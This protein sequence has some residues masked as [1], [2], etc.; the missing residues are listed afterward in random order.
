[1]TSVDTSTRH[2]SVAWTKP[3]NFGAEVALVDFGPGYLRAEG[4]AIGFEP[5]PYRLDYQLQTTS[6]FV[7]SSISVTARGDGWMRQLDLSRTSDGT[8]VV[9]AEQQGTADLPGA[10]GDPAAIAGAL[11]VDLGL[12]PLFNTMPV[13]R[14]GLHDTTGSADFLM[15]WISVPDLS[16]TPSPQRY[17]HLRAGSAGEHL[18]RFEATG[19]GDDFV[20]DILFDADGLV[21][22]YPGIGERPRGAGGA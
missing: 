13:L 7:T 12:S 17:R 15:A 9:R 8:W 21:I 2:R 14:H 20:A 3:E 22:N 5:E 10:G 18:V 19:E 11:D 4:F 6:R 16:V 1:M